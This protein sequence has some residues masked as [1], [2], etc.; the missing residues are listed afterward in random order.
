M[1]KDFYT[2][3]SLLGN[4]SGALDFDKIRKRTEFFA[5]WKRVCGKKF[6]NNSKAYDFKNNI[7]T[8]ACQ[9]SYVAQELSM[10]KR[11]LIKKLNVLTMNLKIEVKDIIF[12]YKIWENP[13]NFEQG[14]QEPEITI[15]YEDYQHIELDKETIHKIETSVAQI[16]FIDEGRKAGLIKRIIDDTK[17]LKYIDSLGYKV[18]PNC[19]ILHKKTVTKCHVCAA[20]V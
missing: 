4:I 1:K 17:R 16:K 14:M 13:Q 19:C 18:C 7:L 8:V 2:L 3:S 9:N 6:E 20:I 10:Y 5:L 12:S 11:E 15:K